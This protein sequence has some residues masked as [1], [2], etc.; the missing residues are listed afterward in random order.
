MPFPLITDVD[1]ANDD[2]K[3]RAILDYAVSQW[4]AKDERIKRIGKLYDS[5][6]GVADER[7]TEAVTKSTGK[8]SK[9]KYVKYRLGRTKLKQLHG[10][11]LEISLTPTITTTNRDAINTKMTKY[12]NL[13]GLSIGKPFIEKTRELGYNVFPGMKIPDRSDK[14]AWNANNFKLTNELVMQ[15]IID[16]KMTTQRLK[17]IFYQNFIDL[18]IT[19]EVYGKVERNINGIDT[20]R[21][22]P[23]KFALYEE[24]IF[25]PF[26][27][28]SPYMG[29]VRPLFFTEIATNKEFNL[30]K[31]QLKVLEQ[32]GRTYVE[33]PRNRDIRNDRGRNLINVYTCQWKGIELVRVKISPVDGSDVPYM[34]I[35]SDEYYDKNKRQIERDVQQGK[36]AIE[37]YERE[38]LW[39]ASRLGKDVYTKAK[40]ATNIIQKMNEN[41]KYNVDYDYCGMLFCTV[42]GIRVSVQEVIYELEKIYD[43]IRFHINR[44]LKKLKGNLAYFDEAFTPKGKKFTDVIHSITEDGMIRFN[45][46]AEGNTSGVDSESNK[47]GVGA[48]NLGQNQNLT[49]LLNQAMDIERVMDRVTGMNDNRQG[50]SRPTTTATANVNSIDASRSMTYDLFYFMQD[51]IERTLTKLCEKT[52]TNI[53]FNGEDQRQFIMDDGDIMYMMTTKNLIEDNYGA[54]ITDGRKEKDILTKIEGL[55]PQEINAGNI[56]TK[57]VAKFWMESSFAAAIRVLD[58]AHAEMDKIRQQEIGQ[59]QEAQKESTQAQIQ[60][61]DH[62]LQEKDQHDKDMELLRIEGEKEI[63]QLE[64]SLDMQK[65]S[66][67]QIHQGLQ[68]QNE[69]QQGNGNQNI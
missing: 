45:S 4:H 53:T 21:Y 17:S 44:E 67:K 62:T 26:M 42:D 65:E 39:E 41:N 52:K 28:K 38:I 57:D 14:E 9:T 55:F 22:I 15:N 30:T 66:T 12:K 51:Y 6:N 25:D 34:R 64:K 19:S 29:E 10:E 50:V 13:L 36:Y 23:V 47:V 33:D 68:K 7:E 63:V 61:A 18:T 37:K 8:E 3:T 35:I 43:D 27:E 31:E 59:K 24:A 5:H 40:K 11:F 69:L 49:V 20:Y 46:S 32:V 48:I 56:R 60:M 54:T 2:V 16:D 1:F 58:N